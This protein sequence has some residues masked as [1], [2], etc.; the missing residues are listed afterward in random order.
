MEWN[1]QYESLTEPDGDCNGFYTLGNYLPSIEDE[2]KDGY[3]RF[4]VK[5]GKLGESTCVGHK[6]VKNR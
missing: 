5:Y 1:G 3:Y 4:F 6:S 2:I